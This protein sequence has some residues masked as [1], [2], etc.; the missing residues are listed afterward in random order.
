MNSPII[1]DNIVPLIHKKCHLKSY[2]SDINITWH[3]ISHLVYFRWECFKY[4]NIHPHRQ[5]E[6]HW[7][8]QIFKGG[9]WLCILSY[10][11]KNRKF[12]T[13]FHWIIKSYYIQKW[14]ISGSK[15]PPIGSKRSFKMYRR[16]T[17]IPN[18]TYFCWKKWVKSKDT[19]HQIFVFIGAN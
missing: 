7:S 8:P 11:N 3:K 2:H 16:S 14:Y 15:S 4:S 13:H 12:W 6:P 5:K 17:W 18:A 10:S 1:H 19:F 9:W